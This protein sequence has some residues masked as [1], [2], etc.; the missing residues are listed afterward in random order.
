MKKNTTL[1]NPGHPPRVLAFWRRLVRDA[2]ATGTPTPF[3]IFSVDPIA[4]A[5]EELKALD[6]QPVPVRHWLSC[7]T[8]PVAPLLRWWRRQ[9]RPIEVVS[10]F[11]Y[12]AA[13][14]EG[15]ATED[16]LING[17]AKHRWLPRVAAP[18][19][20]VNFDSPGELT[21]L[22]PLAKKLKWRTGL[23][24]RTSLEHDPE[25]PEFPTQFGFEP[26]E[27]TAALRKLK[28]AGV[29]AE[30]LHFHLRTNVASAAIYERA[31]RE[32]H[33]FCAAVNWW[34]AFLDCGGGLPPRHTFSHAGREFAAGFK[35]SVAA[36]ARRL[37]A[38]AER[39]TRNAKSSQ[40]LLTSAATGL[41]GLTA[42]FRRWLPRF[43]GLRE[44]WLENGRFLS[45]RSGV[46]VIT[47]LDVKARDGLRQLICD[48][49]RTMNALVS[50]WEEHGLFSVPSRGG[51]T[52][53]TA[54]HGPTCMAFDQLTRRSMSRR[55][56]AGDRLVWLEAGAY[57]LPWE[58][59]FSHGLA[60]V[61]WHE[62]GRLALARAAEPFAVWWRASR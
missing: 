48:G 37:A 25:H 28:R 7:K 10:E 17:P 33:A 23:R 38:T 27:A 47:V 39:G 58:T 12:L 32:A 62:S 46:L 30:T 61:L 55:I 42:V 60:A 29:V 49:G 41:E 34:P 14:H 59:R 45:A 8:Q 31:I 50:N 53:L 11:E 57:H 20:R 19:L 13:R 16:I 9:G 6:D 54:V 24:L 4:E 36:D 2:L 15:F 22:L 5:V 18:G 40:S 3:Y 51:P 35:P 52:V 44:V 26:A 21:A 43:A 1:C 56:R